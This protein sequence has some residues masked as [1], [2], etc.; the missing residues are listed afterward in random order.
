MIKLS[1]LVHLHRDDVA[2]RWF[3]DNNKVWHLMSACDKFVPQCEAE[4]SGKFGPW[5]HEIPDKAQACPVCEKLASQIM[6][7]ARPY[8]YGWAKA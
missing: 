1:E 5:L 6:L 7:K 8:I 4:V 2:Q 3:P